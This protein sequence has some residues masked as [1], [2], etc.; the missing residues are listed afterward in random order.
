MKIEPRINI[1][2]VSKVG[3][4]VSRF[5]TPITERLEVEAL[6]KFDDLGFDPNKIIQ[7]SV[8]GAYEIPLAAQSLLDSGCDGVVTLGAVIRGETTHYDYVCNAVERGCS[9]LQLEYKKPV[10]FGVLTTENGEQALARSGGSKE[11]KGK[12]CVEVLFEMLQMQMD[13]KKSQM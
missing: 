7:L 8:P 12:E 3:L 10:V 5:N 4:V 6:K 13:L 1:E 9:Q 11:N 2:N